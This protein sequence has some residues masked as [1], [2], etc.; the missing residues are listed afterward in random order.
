M[1]YELAVEE[2]DLVVRTQPHYRT[3]LGHKRVS[4]IVVAKNGCAH[5]PGCVQKR[6]A[7]RHDEDKEKSL[8]RADYALGKADYERLECCKRVLNGEEEAAD[9]CS[10]RMSRVVT[11]VVIR[12]PHAHGDV[13]RLEPHGLCQGKPGGQ[14]LLHR[15]EAAL[16]SHR[17]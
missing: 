10:G 1:P 5:V 11:E 9:W 15:K 3:T 2:R 4:L 13:A 7:A 12:M 8:E 16:Q 6:L 17:E 14:R